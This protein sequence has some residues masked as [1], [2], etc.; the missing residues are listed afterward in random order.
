MVCRLAVIASLLGAASVAQAA[1]PPPAKPRGPDPRELTESMLGPYVRPPYEPGSEDDPNRPDYE[2]G[3]RKGPRH[4][5]GF[6]LRL[7]G[8]LGYGSD[9]MESDE[10]R[11]EDFTTGEPIAFS[12]RASGVAPATEIAIGFTPLSG[13]VIA[14]G[15]YTASIVSSS[16]SSVKTAPNKYEFNISQLALFAAALDFYVDP[17]SGFHVQA[18]FGV[19]TFVAGQ[20]SASGGPEARAHTAVGPGLMLGVG[21]EWFVADEWS[22]GIGGRVLYA[23]TEGRDPAGITWQHRTIAPSFMLTATYH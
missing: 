2:L 10:G 5:G 20:G 8:G 23:W 19:G 16:A 13:L 12:G 21:Y 6:Y 18:G 9:G 7:G 11:F 22:L 17:N 4:H 3:A 14:G 1:E 15:V